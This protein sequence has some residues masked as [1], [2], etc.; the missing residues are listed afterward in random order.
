MPE[1]AKL[2]DKNTLQK[3]VNSRVFARLDGYKIY[4]EQPFVAGFSAKDVGYE[5]AE[6][7]ILVQGIIDLLAVKGDEAIILDY[8]ATGKSREEMLG[9]YKTQL[10]IYKK[11]VEKVMKLK[12][13][14][15]ILFN[16]FTCETVEVE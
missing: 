15:T 14:K 8:K 5:K 6:G 3:I 10:E 12:V 13:K 16:V 9:K 2:L 11:A 4:R 7:E 1:Q